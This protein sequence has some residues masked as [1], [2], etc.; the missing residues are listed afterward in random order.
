MLYIYLCYNHL[1][2]SEFYTQVQFSDM[3]RMQKYNN[4]QSFV[5]FFPLECDGSD[6]NKYFKLQEMKSVWLLKKL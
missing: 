2:Y 4:E 3:H 5:F 1:I 6:E